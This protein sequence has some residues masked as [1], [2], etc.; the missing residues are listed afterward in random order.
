MNVN[1]IMQINTNNEWDPLQKIIVGDATGANWPYHDP[2]YR[3]EE[4]RTLWK[5]TPLPRGVVDPRVIDESNEDLQTLADTLTQLGVEVVRP[6]KNDFY[7]TQGMYNY[8][9]RDRLL[10]AGDVVVDPAMMY[11]CR[12]QEIEYLLPH[13]NGAEIRHMPRDQDMVLD[14]ANVA[15][16]GDTWLYLVSNSGNQKA[17][18]WLQKQFPEIKIIPVNFYA[19]VHIDSTICPVGPNTVILN[20]HRVNWDNL[21]EYLNDWDKIWVED[22]VP[23]TFHEYPY[24][25]KWIG[26]NVLSIDH[27]TVIV[28][29]A[30]N[31]LIRQLERRNFTV[32]PL[33]LR[34]SRTLG[35]GFHCVTLDLIRQS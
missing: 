12:D 31:D 1:I 15:R 16:F 25:S 7:K 28:D 18:E 32:V 6:I 22:C 27:N 20:A 5:E 29:Q 30:Q 17:L 10:I 2:V 9:P 11:G 35:G 21:P 23:Q 13:L 26:M 3:L 14:A 33:T 8:C 4:K 34:H 24:A 19:G